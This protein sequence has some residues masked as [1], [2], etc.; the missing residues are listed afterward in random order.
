MERIFYS[1]SYTACRFLRRGGICI[2]QMQRGG[3]Y[4]LMATTFV[5]DFVPEDFLQSSVRVS[6]T[7]MP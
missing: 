4:P 5:F 2:M 7:Q 1:W 3:G 6:V